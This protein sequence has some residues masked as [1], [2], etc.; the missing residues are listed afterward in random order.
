MKD[1][2]LL[3]DIGAIDEA[4]KD[5]QDSMHAPGLGMCLQ[6]LELLLVCDG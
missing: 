3:V 4:L 5:V 1:T 6:K 2:S